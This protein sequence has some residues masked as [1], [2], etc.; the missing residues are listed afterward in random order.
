[1]NKGLDVAVV[2]GSAAGLLTAGILARAGRAVEVF[3]R[4]TRPDPIRR[5]LIVT[6]ALRPL[7]G[8]A[9]D[10]ATVNEINRFE[11]FADGR[12]AT[13]ELERPDL[14]VERARVVTA[15]A[16]SARAAGA[17]IS[18]GTRFLGLQGSNYGVGLALR[19]NGGEPRAIVSDV[20]VG[21]DGANSKVARAAGWPPQPTVPL[22]QAIVEMPTGMAAD[23][24]RVWF[25]PDDT[26]YFYWLVPESD[27]RGALGV[28]GEDGATTRRRL[29]RFLEEHGFKALGYQGAVIPAYERWIPVREKVGSGE[30]YLV[31][32]AA[33]QVKVSTVGGLVTGLKGAAAVADAILDG[34][35][36]RALTRLRRELNLHLLIRRAMHD[37]DQDDYCF[38]LDQ[39]NDAAKRSLGTHDRDDASKI[40]WS[41]L[42]NRPQLLLRGIRSLLLR[43]PVRR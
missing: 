32:D 6:D 28:I 8:S 31:G 1:M 21:A 22:V 25:R 36:D 26:P 2:G 20:V 29:D 23:T 33:G 14:I 38:V 4:A 43:S 18:Y 37:F 16:D 5:T 19:P 30:V 15:L 40:L 13:I 34:G 17:C 35:S 9:A 12:V 10:E 42:R 11:L 7:L 3:E 24:S 27:S 39:L 41:L